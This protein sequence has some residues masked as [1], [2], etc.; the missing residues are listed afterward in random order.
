MA[1]RSTAAGF[2][3]IELLVAIGILAMVAV[4]GWRGLD[5]IVRSREVLNAQLDQSRGMQ[6]TFAQMQSDCDHLAGASAAAATGGS[7]T[8]LNGRANLS[9]EQDRLILVRLAAS[10]LE[11][12]QLQVVTYR[13][14]GGMLTRRESNGTR[15]L[16]VLDTLWQAARDDTDTSTADVVLMRGVDSMALRGQRNLASSAAPEWITL[17]NGSK[18][19]DLVGIEVTLQLPGQA[20]GLSKVFL[21][22][23]G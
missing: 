5:S 3:L 22:G 2:T 8:L 11:P 4:L 1:R 20:A 16:A 14:L 15:D 13:L 9:A 6:L 19:G 7:N 21:L 18:T 23:P 12:Q 17:A 10:E